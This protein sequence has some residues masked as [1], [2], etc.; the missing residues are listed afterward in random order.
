KAARRRRRRIRLTV[1]MIAAVLAGSAAVLLANGPHHNRAPVRPHA[2]AAA[3]SAVQLPAVHV[4]WVDYNGRLH[5]GSLTTAQWRV[6]PA[7]TSDPVVPLIAERAPPHW[8]TTGGT[9]WQIES[10]APAP[11]GIASPGF[12][13]AVFASPDG[14][15]VF[16]AQPGESLLGSPAAGGRSRS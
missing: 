12:G 9:S 15:Q 14:R 13:M 8:V 11:G 4:A 7:P 3:L 10:L 1:G 5:I 16:I 6:A 2:S